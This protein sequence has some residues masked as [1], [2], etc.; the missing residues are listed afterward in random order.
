M[1]IETQ[2]VGDTAVVARLDSMPLRIHAR[3]LPTMR[4]LDVKLHALV[5]S[6]LSGAVL[7]RR[8]GRLAQSQN[9]RLTDSPTE[10]AAAVG[11]NRGTVPYGAIHEFGGTTRA[12]VIEAINAAT[13]RFQVGGKTVFAKKVNHPGSKIP[14][15]SFLRSSLKEMAPE[16]IAEIKA[17]AVTE[18]QA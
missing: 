8:T 11:F 13:L 6:K 10:I 5:V 3:L 14:E 4:A 9:M 12:H 17:A 16:A 15:R 18:A 2:I 7:H 1:N